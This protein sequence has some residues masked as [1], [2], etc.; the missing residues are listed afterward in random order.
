MAGRARLTVHPSMVQIADWDASALRALESSSGHTKL[1]VTARAWVEIEWA[2]EI[3]A[4]HSLGVAR[5]WQMAAR[6]AS[7]NFLITAGRLFGRQLI[8]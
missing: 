2:L 4:R 1:E 8:L 6:V 5:V 7:H 3:D